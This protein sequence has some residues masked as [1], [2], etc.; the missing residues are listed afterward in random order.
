MGALPTTHDKQAEQVQ[1]VRG[2][3]AAALYALGAGAADAVMVWIQE[4]SAA[5][6]HA[7]AVVDAV[8]TD[9]P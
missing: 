3:V 4:Q 2:D 6:V 7:D 1:A 8:A 9:A 5:R